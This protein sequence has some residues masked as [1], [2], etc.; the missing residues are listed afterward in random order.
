MYSKKETASPPPRPPLLSNLLFHIS[1]IPSQQPV[2][3]GTQLWLIC[4]SHW[5]CQ[6]NRQPDSPSLSPESESQFGAGCLVQNQAICAVCTPRLSTVG[7]LLDYRYFIVELINVML[8]GSG[9]HFFLN[10]LY[11]NVS[12]WSVSYKLCKNM[13]Y[14]I[15][16]KSFSWEALVST[17]TYAFPHRKKKKNAQQKY[18]I[19]I[20]FYIGFWEKTHKGWNQE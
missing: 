6:T 9:R 11:S 16:I 18:W 2:S 3:S 13:K 5:R 19:F 10:W 4:L 15:T 20:I 1:T 17:L 8:I 14:I 7:S 12:F